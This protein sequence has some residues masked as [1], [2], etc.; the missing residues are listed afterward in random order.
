[1]FASKLA[2][3]TDGFFVSDELLDKAASLSHAEITRICDDAIKSAIL[4]DT[5]VINDGDMIRI[6]DERLAVYQ[7]RA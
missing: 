2:A 1:M 4:S 5:N 3:F 6:I 7:R